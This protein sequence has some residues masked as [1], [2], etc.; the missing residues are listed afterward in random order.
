MNLPS[1]NGKAA[2]V[3][4]AEDFAPIISLF[5]RIGRP[6]E[7]A[8]ASLWLTSDLSSYITGATLP[9]DAGYVNR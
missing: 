9:V 6:E 1:L 7:V 3:T 2:I 5:N 4:G 8:Q